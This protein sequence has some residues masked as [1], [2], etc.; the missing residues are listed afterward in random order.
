MHQKGF[1]SPILVLLLIIVFLLAGFW[2][3]TND[4]NVSSSAQIQ[5]VSTLASGARSGLGVSVASESGNWDL[6]EY[7]CVTAE[8][9]KQALTSGKRWGT[10]G[11]GAAAL[12][13][14]EIEASA[15]WEN[16]THLKIF[17]KPSWQNISSQY[18]VLGL[19][20]V[21]G[22][23]V[24]KLSDGG[25]AFDAVLIPLENVSSRYFK[26]VTFSD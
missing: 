7:L 18:K 17:V 20:D 25:V 23:E 16:Y 11:G 4:I 9:C 21:P 2:F 13:Q 15:E 10:V 26:S 5:G 8:E 12:H 1:A 14:V 22:S 3:F 19:G 6:Y 24:V